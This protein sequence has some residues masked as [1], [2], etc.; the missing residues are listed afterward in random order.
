MREKGERPKSIMTN[1]PYIPIPP[2]TKVYFDYTMMS[3]FCKCRRYF[4][5]R[6]V[7]DLVP[8]RESIAPLF[9]QYFHKVLSVWYQTHDPLL[10]I[11]EFDDWKDVEWDPN[12]TRDRA[13]DIWMRYVK[14][15]PKEPWKIVSNEI[16]VEMKIGED[17]FY[18]YH[19]IGRIDLAIQWHN[20]PYIYGMDHKTTSQLGDSYFNQFK[21]SLQM[22]G[23]TWFLRQIYGPD[24]QGMQINAISTAKTAG[25]GKVQAFARSIVT[26]TDEDLDLYT[27]SALAKMRDMQR[28]ISEWDTWAPIEGKNSDLRDNVFY[29]NEDSCTDYG[30]CQFRQLC[31][32]H[33]DPKTIENDF[34]KSKWDPRTTA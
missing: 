27:R 15:Y 3:G 18:E 32:E 24:V 25:T 21:P 10:A 29:P 5:L 22:A 1:S 4:Y 26:F 23:Y 17:E 13:L 16:P 2:K 20:S 14:T 34:A 9:G 33:L 6:F 31:L 30:S 11:K 7:E 8:K 28:C 12:R 19:L